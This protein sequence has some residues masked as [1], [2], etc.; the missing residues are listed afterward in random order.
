MATASAAS[1]TMSLG[2]LLL[3]FKWNTAMK[4]TVDSHH[5]R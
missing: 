1:L 3:V 5:L 4:A 2:R